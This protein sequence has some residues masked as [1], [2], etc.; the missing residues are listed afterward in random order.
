NHYKVMTK[1]YSLFRPRHAFGWSLLFFI[2]NLHTHAQTISI[3]GQ[4]TDGQTPISG[5]SILVKN[6]VQGTVSDFDGRFEL[7][8]EK[9]DTLLISYLGYKPMELAIGNRRTIDVVLQEDATALREVTI[10]A[11]YYN[12]TERTKTG[13]IARL[14]AKEIEGQPII[15]PLAAMA[16][17]MTGV[18]IDQTSGVPGS[19]FE[20]RTRGQNSIMGGDASLSIVDGV[21]FDGQTL[22]SSNSSF[23]IIPLGNI[24][25]LNAINPDSIESIEVLKDADATAIY[26]SRGANGVVLITTKKGN[27]GKTK[28]TITSRT[29]VGSI[30]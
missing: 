13:N 6:T 30:T 9:T 21:P 4:I 27:Q 15:N 16:G 3:S 1:F 12:T 29:G 5:A 28:L 19:G 23:T 11:G 20:V 18:D 8:A 22:G 10:N 24:S 14:T 17:R 7:Y 2:F 25:P 26:G